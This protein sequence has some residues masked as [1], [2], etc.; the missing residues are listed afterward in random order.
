MVGID[1]R[2]EFDGILKKWGQNIY[3]QRVLNPINDDEEVPR[4]STTLE[5][6]TVRSMN[7]LAS[8]FLADIKIE[9]SEGI[10][11]PTEMVFWFKWDVNPISGDRIYMDVPRYPSGRDPVYTIDHA[12]PKYGLGGRIEFWACGCTRVRPE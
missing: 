1:L 12:D 4:Y 10:E 6:H 5:R 11:F 9:A 8:R 3:L 2:V 7:V